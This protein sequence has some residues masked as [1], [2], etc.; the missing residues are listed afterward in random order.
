MSRGFREENS[1]KR[2]SLA[3]AFQLLF[4][5]PMANAS[6]QRILTCDGAVV[7]VNEGERRNLQIWVKDLNVLRAMHDQ[8]LENLSFGQ[9]EAVIYGSTLW[10]MDFA[11]ATGPKIL[12]DRDHAKGVFY[13]QDFSYFHADRMQPLNRG[14]VG[15]VVSVFREGTGLS[16][17]YQNIEPRGC[18]GKIVPNPNPEGGP[19]DGQW[20]SYCDGE[21][22]TSIA[23]LAKFHFEGCR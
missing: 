17:Q 19:G 5:A 7:D 16:L 18:A 9:T 23:N 13:P 8:G 1:M 20:G 6:W 3:L 2:F 14:W 22:Y 11:D 15:R 10:H 21:D 12:Y 4:L